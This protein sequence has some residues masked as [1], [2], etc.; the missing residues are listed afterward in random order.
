[1]SRERRLTSLVVFVLLFTS[2]AYFYQG[3]GWNQ[4]S[5]FALVR[6]ITSQH[7]LRIDAF[8]S[9]TGDR[10]LYDGH[11][12]CDKAPGL[13]L[14]AVPLVA[15][16]RAVL[17]VFGR[18]PDDP[19]GLAFLSYLATVLIVGLPTALAGVSLY[20][21][22]IKLGAS[23]G[24]AFFAAI[25][26]GLG[27]PTWALAT[28]F[29][30][31]AFSAALLVLAFASACR[32]GT[33]PGSSVH[34]DLS[35]GALIGSCAGWATVSE[36]PAAVPAV[37]IAS[38]ALV[39]ARQLRRNRALRVL[40]AMTAT[41]LGAAAVLL[42]YQYLCFRSPFHVAYGTAEGFDRMQEGVFGVTLRS[43]H[44]VGRVLRQILFGEY[45]G[46]LPLA[47]VLALAP[48]GLAL[49]VCSGS[50][51]RRAGIVACTVVAYYILL[52]AHYA[53]WDGGWSYGPRH[54]SPAIPFLSL[55]LGELWTRVSRTIRWLLAGVLIYG[56]AL[57]LV[58]VSTMP[59]P[60]VGV[61]N[62]TSDLLW[63]AFR[64]GDLSLNTQRFDAR[65]PV[66]VDFRAHREPK[67]AFNLGMKLGLAGTG[68]LLPLF[69][70]WAACAVALG[71]WGSQP[72]VIA[73]GAQRASP[74]RAPS[75][76]VSLKKRS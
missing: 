16:A 35:L 43:L 53:Y 54:V 10:A 17:F 13:S 23:P 38:L 63:P 47:P 59:M 7:T 75:T 33:D 32:V 26:F 30:G 42:L 66:D 64:E 73:R 70:V 28:I 21:L 68:S 46:L 45:R 52:N 31:H 61:A 76:V 3:G 29:I 4:N 58:A 39:N 74:G 65:D 57:T 50:R 12:Y 69:L 49:L 2:Y 37:L 55:G 27:T 51:A 44:R 48:V 1:V 24:G 14:T 9:S 60:P 19:A 22:V 41:A 6:S 40:G 25:G 62:P 34:T 8:A 11:Y 18:D 72:S 71:G 5:R 15:V 67:V 36:F 56:V 20:S